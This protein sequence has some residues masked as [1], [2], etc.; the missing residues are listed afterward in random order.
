MDKLELKY[1]H[2]LKKEAGI[3]NTVQ[4]IVQNHL[5]CAK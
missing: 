1:G 3:Q 2:I 4:Y 5:H